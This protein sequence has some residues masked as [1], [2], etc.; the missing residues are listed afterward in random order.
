MAPR[1]LCS[2]GMRM[3]IVR[4]PPPGYALA[5]APT[6]PQIQNTPQ[7]SVKEVKIPSFEFCHLGS[8][9]L[10]DGTMAQ[11]QEVFEVI[12]RH[13]FGSVAGLKGYREV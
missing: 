12:M 8:M 5:G 13:A 4:T 3:E 10:K 11:R 1:P 7:A 9:M 2:C 6:G